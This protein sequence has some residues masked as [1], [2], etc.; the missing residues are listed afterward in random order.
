MHGLE[1]DREFQLRKLEGFG[2]YCIKKSV[3]TEV[4][5]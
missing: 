3:N 5:E 1:Q 4:V 2:N